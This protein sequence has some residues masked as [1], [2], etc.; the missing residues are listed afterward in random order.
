MSMTLRGQS[1]IEFLLV[2]SMIISVVLGVLVPLFRE[3]ELS[4]AIA[5]ARVGVLQEV[6][7]NGSLVFSSID[8]RVSGGTNVTIIPNIY[9]ENAL[10]NS[11][12]VRLAVL[13]RIADTFSPSRQPA[14]AGS[15]VP[16]LYY[17]YCVS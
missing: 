9:Q 10:V 1:G 13:R 16:A 6:A 8:Y 14:G 11:S 5:A 15:C 2:A 17:T 3:S 12:A 4:T 7:L